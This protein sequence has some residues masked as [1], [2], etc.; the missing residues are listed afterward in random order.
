MNATGVF[1]SLSRSRGFVGVAAAV[2]SLFIASAVAGQGCN[3]T[4]PAGAVQQNDECGG[5]DP[6]PNGGCN[7]PQAG[8][9]FQN[10]GP[11]ASGGSITVCGTVGTF[12][13]GSRDLD[14]FRVTLAEPGFLTVSATHLTNNIILFVRDG[15]NCVDDVTLFGQASAAC[16][17]TTPAIFLPAGDHTVIITVP[18]EADG[19][20]P[21]PAP[22]VLTI[23]FEG[24]QFDECGDPAAGSCIDANNIPGCDNFACCE[25]ICSFF[26]TCCDFGWDDLC[27]EF[28]IQ[29]CGLFLYECDPP[30]N[31]PANDCATAAQDIGTKVEVS[32]NN[33]NATLDGPEFACAQGRDVWFRWQA[34]GSGDADINVTTTGW[35]PVVSVFALPAGGI[36]DPTELPNLFIGCATLAG[37]G[38]TVFFRGFD[39]GEFFLISV[40]AQGATAGGAGTIEVQR[41]D[42]VFN[43][44]GTQPVLFNGAAT[45]LGLS[46]GNLSP[47]LPQRWTATPFTVADPAGPENGFNVNR[48]W[49]YGFTPGTATNETLNYIVW[50]RS[51][52][53]SPPVDGDQLLTGAVPFPTPVDLP[54]GAPLNEAHLI[55]VDFDLPAGD[56]WL[57]VYADNSSGGTIES[58]FA[59]FVNPPDGIAKLDANGDPFGYRSAMFPSPGFLFFQ[60]PETTLAAVPGEDPTTIYN[61]GF[62]MTGKPAIVDGKKPGDCP[63]DLTGDGNVDGADLG[64]LL[65]QWGPCPGCSGDFTGDGVVDGADL[66]ALLNNWGACP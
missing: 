6:D 24:G 27:V 15:S 65:N 64:A 9:P 52:L 44:G 3:V 41:W 1:R 12:G 33:A 29:E 7:F 66:G 2:S 25:L 39:Q 8:N 57:T 14:W 22:Y 5:L 62:R 42:D 46:S 26:T 53:E 54:E 38:G 49:A 34:G 35:A 63:W 30:A 4:C 47:T 37:G 55:T 13:D 32:F 36:L 11:I 48:L 23:S 60:L 45:N 20:A 21:C 58:Q 28:A 43:T 19:G 17:F 50:S 51:S 10:L 40:G 56:Y 59:W 31:A 18:F 16:P 61:V